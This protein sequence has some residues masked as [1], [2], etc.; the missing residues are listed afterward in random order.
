MKDDKFEFAE[1]A[2]EAVEETRAKMRHYWLRYDLSSDAV[3]FA[4][5]MFCGA[6]LRRMKGE[7]DP[8]LVVPRPSG[9]NDV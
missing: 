3:N 1:V 6:V 8:D 9:G 7:P 2:G 4:L 5:G